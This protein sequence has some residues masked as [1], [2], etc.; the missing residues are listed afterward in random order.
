M[1][2]VIE[3]LKRKAEGSLKAWKEEENKKVLFI[4]GPKGSGKTTLVTKFAKENYNHF[5]H[6]DFDNNP[7]H[8]SIFFS[9]FDLASIIKQITLKLRTGQLVPNETLIFLDEVHLSP[10][11]REAAKTLI[12]GNRFD[13][14]IAS[15]FSGANIEKFDPTILEH[16]Q[17]LRL[18]SLD[19]EEFMWAN[20][21]SSQAIDDVY[22]AF[23]SKTPIPTVLHEQFMELF[24]E[25]MVVGGMPEVVNGFVK[26]HDFREVIKI[27]RRIYGNYRSAISNHLRGPNKRKANQ[28]FTSIASQLIKE[29]KKFQYGIVEDKGNARKFESSVLW[30]YDAE[31]I[32]ISFQLDDLKLPFYDNVRHNIFK[33][34]FQDVGL[35]MSRLGYPAQQ[36]IMDGDF[37]YNNY[38]VLEATIADL[39]IKRDIRLFY[40]SRT[41]TLNM[42]FI[43]DVGGT[44]TA[45]SV[46]DADN[47]KAKALTSLYEN[48]DLKFGIELT[49]D[50]ISVSDNLHRYP[51][52]CVMFF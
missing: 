11:A 26:N 27:Q 14:I 24:K 2:L 42:E 7:V 9:S 28:C 22:R 3:M 10:K 34:Y 29:N 6:L 38:A 47:T 30:L 46:I 37:T 4:Q 32:N 44:L 52:Y 1:M 12:E 48:Y 41:T 17:Y 5:V 18:N 36:A 45:L 23:I 21:V 20:G 51:L 50:N 40:F 8:K 33:V 16:E 43:L 15:S 25:Y 49:K 35:L 19:L 31:M 39:L 13:V